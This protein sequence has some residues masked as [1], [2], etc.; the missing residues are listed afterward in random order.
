MQSDFEIL[1]FSHKQKSWWILVDPEKLLVELTQWALRLP[2][3]AIFRTV[4]VG[5]L[6]VI[7]V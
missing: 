6:L 2:D 7:K 3:L 5:K 4:G 1:A